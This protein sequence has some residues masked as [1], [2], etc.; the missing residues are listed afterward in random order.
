[1]NL[2]SKMFS[3]GVAFET[4]FAGLFYASSNVAIAGHADRPAAETALPAGFLAGNDPR[5][6]TQRSAN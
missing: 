1:M 3:D 2:L 4:V 6:M 5:A